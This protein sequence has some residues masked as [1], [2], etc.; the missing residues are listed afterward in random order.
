MTQ[1]DRKFP[2]VKHEKVLQIKLN[3][4]LLTAISDESLTTSLAKL[5]LLDHMR[6]FLHSVFS[7]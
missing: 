3:K 6:Q 5:S 4:L 1:D 7:T 2:Q